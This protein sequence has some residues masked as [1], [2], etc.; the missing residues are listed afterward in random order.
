MATT[1]LTEGREISRQLDRSCIWL[2]AAKGAVIYEGAL[3]V[4]GA[5]GYARPATKAAGLTAAGYAM[6]RADNSK[7][8]N[9]AT[10]VNVWRGG[11]QLDN[12]IG[13]G[14]ITQ[15]DVLQPCYIL[16]DHTVTKTAEGSSVAGKVLGLDGDQVIVEIY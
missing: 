3:V 1:G 4:V 9:G 15:A 2:P 8:D 7:G 13:A 11:A 5:D 10:G 16:D 12:D 14:A 6:D